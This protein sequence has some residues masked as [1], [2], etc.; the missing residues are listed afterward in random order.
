MIAPQT[1]CENRFLK[2]RRIDHG[3][4]RGIFVWDWN[5]RGEMGVMVRRERKKNGIN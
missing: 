5:G 2:A 1:F 3:R 4:R